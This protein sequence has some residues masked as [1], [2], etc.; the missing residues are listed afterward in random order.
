MENTNLLAEFGKLVL[1]L[2]GVIV[3]VF[4]LLSGPVGWM[5]LAILLI[6]AGVVYAAV[7]E[8]EHTGGGPDQINCPACG[9]RVLAADDA[10]EYCGES[11]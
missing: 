10:C 3:V 9:A 1:G 11:L 2:I 5:L 8:R 4:L 6:T 7:R